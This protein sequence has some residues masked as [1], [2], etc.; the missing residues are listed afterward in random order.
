VSEQRDEHLAARKALA[1]IIMQGDPLSA[2]RRSMEQRM[3]QLVPTLPPVLD[4]PRATLAITSE[5]TVDQLFDSRSVDAHRL[6]ASFER[7]FADETPFREKPAEE[8]PAPVAEADSLEHLIPQ[9]AGGD[10]P[11]PNAFTDLAERFGASDLERMI[12]V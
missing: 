9:L 2:I 12:A 3:Q 4:L 8:H 1:T 5:V 6:T 10:G 7:A 11:V